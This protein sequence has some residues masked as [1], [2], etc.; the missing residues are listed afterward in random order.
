MEDDL[1][2]PPFLMH[3][4]PECAIVGSTRGPMCGASAVAPARTLCAGASLSRLYYLFAPGDSTLPVLCATPPTPETTPASFLADAPSLCSSG[5]GRR[6]S[7]PHDA[8][9]ARGSGRKEE[10]GA[11]LVV[12]CRQCGLEGRVDRWVDRSTRPV[13]CPAAASHDIACAGVARR[14]AGGD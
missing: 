10:T 13:L 9:Q 2:I 3:G 7:H 8:K 14:A 1:L 4:A 12:A 11:Q 5:T 6:A